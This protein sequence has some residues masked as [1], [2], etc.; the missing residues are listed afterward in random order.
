M[1]NILAALVLIS[2]AACKNND[3]KNSQ[4]KGKTNPLLDINLDTVPKTTI[5]E[6]DTVYNFGTIT[7]GDTIIH[8]FRFVNTGAKPLIIQMARASCGCTVV[9]RPDKPIMPG[10]TSELKATFNSSGKAGE[11]VEKMVF[12]HSNASPEFAPFKL[13]G[14]VEKSKK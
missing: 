8:S 13:K 4:V 14:K 3:D 5:K 11:A 9:D 7:E 6:I 2:L 12:V 10:D 1:K